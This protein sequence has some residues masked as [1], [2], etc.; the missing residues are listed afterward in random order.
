M[1]WGNRTAFALTLAA[2]S[3]CTPVPLGLLIPRERAFVIP[4]GAMEPTLLIGDRIVVEKVDQ[5][6][7]AVRRGDIVAFR[8]PIDETQSFLKRVIGVPGD[9]IKIH[10]KNLI[11]NGR[12]VD[13]PYVVHKT[14]YVDDYRDNFPAAP[15][16][17]LYEPAIEM[18]EENVVDDELVVPAGKYFVMGDN[19]DLSLDSRYWGLLPEELIFA[20]PW[21]IY[22]SADPGDEGESGEARWD[23]V[24]MAI[25]NYP[26]GE[27]Q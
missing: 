15:S 14:E 18:L 24:G 19:R 20:R 4:T 23:R 21:R 10:E 7:P 2:L 25:E 16:V 27:S 13:E 26:L 11:L 17:H 1:S 8:Y 9:R 3:A 5:P 6:N 22:Y 12:P